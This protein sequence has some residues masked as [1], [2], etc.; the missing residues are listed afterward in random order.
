VLVA[1]P[2]T[3]AHSKRVYRCNVLRA[4]GR[5]NLAHCDTMPADQTGRLNKPEERNNK[6][7]EASRQPKDKNYNLI[8][9][10]YQGSE[11]FETF[12]AYVQDKIS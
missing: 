11:N 5:L 10:L 9:A 7:T 4:F 8:S 6:M 2:R 12:K 1:T 3:L